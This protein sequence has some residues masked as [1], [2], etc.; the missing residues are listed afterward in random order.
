MKDLQNEI[1]L[2]GDREIEQIPSISDKAL[3]INLNENIYGTFAEIG[4]GQE[5]V[6]H[7]FRAG[8]SSGTIAKAMSAYDKDF[9]DAIYGIEDDGRYVTESRLR[10]MLQHE[11]E[12]VEQRLKR[13]KH[14]NK[15]FFSYANTVA[16]IDFAKQYKGHGWVGIIFQLDPD[17][18]YNEIILHIRFKEND[19]KLQQE[20]LGKLG[21]N[22][23][24]G[25][26]YKYNDP[27]RLLRY[28][29]DHIDKDQLEIDTVNFSGPRF[30]QVDNRLMSLQL[31][32]NGMTDAV[33]FDPNAKNVLPAQ[34]LYKKNI[35]ALRGS[36]RPV[37]KV[38]MDMY[39]KSLQM[40]LQ[41]NKVKEENTLVVFEITLS[42]LRSDG[43]IDEKDFLDRA[44]LLCSLGQTV[45]ISNFQ[46]YYKVVEYFSNYT[47]E[48]MGLAMGVNNLID[49]FDE[50][51]Y[52]HLSGGILEAFG[53][54][55]YRDM[56]VYLYPMEDEDGTILTSQNLKVHPRMKE[57]YKF[58]AYN[59]KVID[60][61]DFDKSHLKIFSREVLKMIGSGQPGWEEMLPKGIAEL[62]KR[63]HLFSCDEN[64][65]IEKV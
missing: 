35:L 23:I 27:K 40:F 49:I 55:F 32:R 6:R 65:K 19:A 56:K 53:K 62:I 18:A 39:E 3:R 41:E 13:E 61:T 34:I 44:E 46:E 24:Y 30:N 2:K 52:R 58:F 48:R 42:N 36:F 60:I 37:T 8:A 10:K 21:V 17:E 59:G 11:I 63:D 47:K 43:E 51:Y 14:P 57:L 16:T 33:M 28:L 64:K 4:A 29:Y 26:F 25:A 1:R 50:K 45:L 7:F 15:L 22:L 20:T 38:N 5:T 9:S 31:V 54:L 12:L